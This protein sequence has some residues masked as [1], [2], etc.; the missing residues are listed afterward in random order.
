MEAVGSDGKVATQLVRLLEQ[1]TMG[2]G[3]DGNI[4]A[5]FEIYIGRTMEEAGG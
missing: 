5:D 3:Y 2:T 1:D 4:D